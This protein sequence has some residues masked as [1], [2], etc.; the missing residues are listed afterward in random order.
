M[1][2][3]ESVPVLK[4]SINWNENGNYDSSKDKKYT[5]FSGTE[6]VKTWATSSAKAIVT[7]TGYSTTKGLLVKAILFPKPT[8]FHFMRDSLIFCFGFGLIALIGV[9]SLIDIT[10]W[11]GTVES[12]ITWWCDL[13]TIAIPPALPLAMT[14]GIV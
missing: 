13:V 2:T 6:V 9:V 10:I 14:T 8:K 12:N 5:L 11:S 3:G 7:W 4:V 1:L